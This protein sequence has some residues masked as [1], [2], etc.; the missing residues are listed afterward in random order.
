MFVI[1]S[2]GV[3]QATSI[4]LNLAIPTAFLKFSRADEAEADYL[5]L[6][7]MYKAGY[8]PQGLVQMFEKIKALDKEKPGKLAR[9]FETHPPTPNRILK[10]QQ[11]IRDILPPRPEYILDT[12][13]FDQVKARLAAIENRKKAIPPD[14]QKKPSLRRT[15]TADNSK[16]Q[17]QP[18]KD[19]DDRPTLQRR[20]DDYV[21]A[22]HGQY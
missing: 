15:Q 2:W 8:D 16:G 18:G 9:V 20:D 13:E 1:N 22:N 3:Y 4:A 17:E 7:Y 14:Q 6:Q 5:G 19:G 11:E 12:S 10:C 21:A